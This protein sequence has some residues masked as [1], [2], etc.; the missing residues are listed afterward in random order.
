MGKDIV[1][2][3][4][5]GTTKICALVGK[6]SS[7]DSLEIIGI[8]THPS[9]GL[10]KGVVIDIDDT[11]KSIEKA[12]E[13]AE[14]MAGCEIDAVYVG[15]A[16]GHIKS[17]N[18]EGAIPLKNREITKK[19]IERVIDAASAIS[20]PMD[21][22]IIQ[23]MVQEYIVDE[24][25]GILNPVGMSGVRFGARVHIITAAVTSAQN[26]IK[27]ANKAGLDVCDI[28]LQAIAS[29]DAVLTDEEKKGNIILIDFG[30]GT[31]DMAVFSKGAVR[32]T[33]VLPLGGSNLTYDLS[34]GL[35][36]SEKEAEKIKKTQGCGC[37]SLISK[38]EIVEVS[39]IDGRR[40]RIIPKR[41]IAEILEPRIEEIFSLLHE[42]LIRSEVDI[43]LNC[44]VV[45]TGGSAKLEGI[46]E[47]A[48]KIFNVPVRIG[49]PKDIEGI[50]EIVKEP[51]YATAVGLVLYGLKEREKRRKFRI[52]D[53]NIFIRIM[54]TMKKW[55]NEMF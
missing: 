49:Y 41:K 11:V 22:E 19:D 35:K 13:K 21:R 17:F 4:D 20:I 51:M 44:G 40:R 25:D 30:G 55:F 45:I 9:N 27:C 10:R 24:Q 39:A 54:N 53:S 12:V 26:I 34:I 6:I 15:I 2:G 47:V 23:T 32:H 31:T 8:G 42:D 1:V 52:R 7:D 18:S 48:E 43:N 28:I 16:G 3:L 37:L 50:S 5:I 38:G 36:I 46:I 14:D 33:S 29:S